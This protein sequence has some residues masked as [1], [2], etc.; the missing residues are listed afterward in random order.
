MSGL[1][2]EWDEQKATTNAKNHGVTFDDGTIRI[3]SAR[4]ASVR[5]AKFYP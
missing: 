4:K 1:H 3:I 2:F 5:E